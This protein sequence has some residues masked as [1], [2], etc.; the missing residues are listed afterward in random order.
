MSITQSSKCLFLTAGVCA[1]LCA[2]AILFAERRAW[3]QAP[4]H[5][6]QLLAVALCL[7]A[8]LT[9][10]WRTRGTKFRGERWLVVAAA[11]LS[12]VW[13]LFVIFVFLTLDFSAM[14]G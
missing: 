13:L 9:F 12:G 5:V 2:P 7:P 4:F 1:L 14:D 6:T 3:S 11:V 10:L 8:S